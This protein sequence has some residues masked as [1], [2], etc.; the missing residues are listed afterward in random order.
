MLE[1]VCTKK[2]KYKYLNQ[3]KSYLRGENEM[4]PKYVDSN[5]YIINMYT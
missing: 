5:I 3:L 2:W 4:K 1:N